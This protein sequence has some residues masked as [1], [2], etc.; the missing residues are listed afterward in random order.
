MRALLIAGVMVL[1]AACGGYQFGG[2]QPSPSPAG[3]AVTGHVLSVPCAPVEQQGSMCAGRPVPNLEIDY[4]GGECS[5]CKTVTDAKGNYAIE[6]RS[7]DY[8]VK[9]KTFMRVLSGPL[10]IRVAAGSSQVAD[11][12]IDSGIR[13]PVPQQ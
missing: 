10:K 11:Y 13:V 2:G 9:L 6:L 5:V 4:A 3:G 1:T 12:T 7:G 8:V